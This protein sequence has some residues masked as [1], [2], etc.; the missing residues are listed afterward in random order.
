M[1]RKQVAQITRANW[2]PQWI[3]TLTTEFLDWFVLK[4]NATKP[5]VPL[6]EEHLAKTQNQTIVNIEYDNGAGFNTVV[7][8]LTKPVEVIS[9]PIAEFSTDTKGLYLFV[10]A[11]H[12]L[13]AAKAQQ[14]LK[15]IAKSGNPVAIV[16]GNDDSLWQ[17]VGMLVFVP[18]TVVL[19]SP[20]VKP[21][22]FSRLIFTYLIPVLPL[23]IAI[24]GCLALFKLYNPNDLRELT[25]SL[26][27]PNYTWE[28]GK[29]DN[30]RGGK[31]IY[32]IGNN[33]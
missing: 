17:L 27:I 10:N 3:K 2:C 4:A 28:A 5:F 11:F 15:D 8:H 33:V 31:I 12:Q 22:R 24:D 19:A 18:L 29:R 32:L 16:E 7:P 30:G 20:F 1:K 13:D 21:F 25:S 6:I 14:I 26:K 23:I 9:V